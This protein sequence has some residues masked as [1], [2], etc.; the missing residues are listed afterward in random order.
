MIVRFITFLVTLYV[1]LD[2][3]AAYPHDC[4]CEVRCP[5]Y[6][7]SGTLIGFATNGHGLVITAAHVLEGGNRGAIRCEFGEHRSRARVIGM[8]G[9]NDLAAL[10]V[11]SPPDLPT[12]PVAYASRSDEPY[13]C[14]G[15]PWNAQGGQRWTTGKYVGYD[16]GDL[17]T[18]T[19]V[20]SGYSGG[21]RFNR[22][23]EYTGVISGMRGSSSW[24][25]DQTWGAGGDALLQ[26]IGRYMEV[27]P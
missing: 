21:A 20:I 3:W 12:P 2:V 9:R 16:G 22:H 25:M 19:H 10:D 26:F 8:D 7:G 17:L 11:E 1:G 18:A 15:Y 23:A 27:E 13:T 24:G 5:P 14:V 6:G 4:V